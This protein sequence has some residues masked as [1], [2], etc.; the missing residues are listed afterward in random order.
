MTEERSERQSR[1]YRK[2]DYR[3]VAEGQGFS[4]TLRV[5]ESD[6]WIA[7]ARP[8]LEVMARDSLLR[9]RCSLEGFLESFPEWGE[10]L[11]PVAAAGYPLAPPLARRMMT[12]AT[13]AGVGPMAAVAG[14][15]A[16]AVG[17]DLLASSEWVVVENGGDIFLAGRDFWRLALF[18]GNSP[19]SGRLGIELRASDP[20]VCGVCTSSASVGHSLSLGRADAVTIVAENAALADAAATAAANRVRKPRD[21]ARVVEDILQ[22]SGVTGAVAVLGDSLAAGGE[23]E[24]VE[25]SS[26]SVSVSL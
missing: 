14:V 3:S 9:H 4:F 6:L 5:A 21:L 22:L 13:T 24:L 7:A 17:R 26:K 18:A 1:E 8:G 16:E 12:A 25:L 11:A 10:S 23:L 2:R 20:F 19:L 15:I